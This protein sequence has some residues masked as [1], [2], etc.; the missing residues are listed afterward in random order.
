[1]LPFHLSQN[2]VGLWR[3]ENACQPPGSIQ[4]T[5]T[6]EYLLGSYLAQNLVLSIPMLQGVI[7]EFLGSPSLSRELNMCTGDT[8][9]KG[10]FNTC[11]ISDFM[12]I[13][14]ESCCIPSPIPSPEIKEEA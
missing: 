4:S 12:F 3:A 8:N 1:M 6:S 11:P 10:R 2:S 14:H 5:Q 7:Y 9:T 13:E